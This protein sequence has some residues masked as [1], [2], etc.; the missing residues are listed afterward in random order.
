MCREELEARVAAMASQVILQGEASAGTSP[1]RLRTGGDGPQ[2][3]EPGLSHRRFQDDSAREVDGAAQKA[4]ELHEAALQQLQQQLAVKNLI[5]GSLEDLIP[6]DRADQVS[7][8]V[9]LCQCA[10][11]ACR[12]SRGIWP[13][14]RAALPAAQH[15]GVRSHAGRRLTCAQMLRYQQVHH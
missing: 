8:Q 14:S 4:A 6:A 12:R 11:D 10:L 15:T 7:S 13:A 1:E 9:A 3:Q 5:L 2:Q